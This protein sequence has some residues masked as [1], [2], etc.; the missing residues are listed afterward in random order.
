MKKYLFIAALFAGILSF[1]SCVPVQYVS[2]RPG[3]VTY[4]RPIA[5]G[6][7]Y[8]WI[9][10][11]WM[12]SGGRYTWQEGRWDRPRPGHVWHGGNWTQ[13]HRGYRWNRGHW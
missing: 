5:P 13:G 12:W 3:E 2:A 9:D 7:G 6:E 8:I 10:G 11:D 1:S 4:T